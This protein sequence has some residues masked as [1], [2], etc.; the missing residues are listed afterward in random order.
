MSTTPAISLSVCIEPAVPMAK[1][2]RNAAGL[3]AE[4]L[5]SAATMFARATIDEPTGL[6]ELDSGSEASGEAGDDVMKCAGAQ[7]VVV[8][9]IVNAT[10]NAAWRL[11]RRA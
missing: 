1:V 9:V 10:A 3:A 5:S 11:V 8:A 2:A 4:A 7:P 6:P